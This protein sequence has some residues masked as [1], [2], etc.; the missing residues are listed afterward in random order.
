MDAAQ[1]KEARLR[2]YRE[3]S[4]RMTPV[5]KASATFELMAVGIREEN[6]K[7]HAQ[8]PGDSEEQIQKRY[9]EKCNEEFVR[10]ALDSGFI[11]RKL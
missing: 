4:R 10:D 3:L 7:L 11:V 1:R 9:L 2:V 5:E 6:D 8:F